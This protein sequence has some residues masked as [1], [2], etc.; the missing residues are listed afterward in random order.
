MAASFQP[1][2]PFTHGQ[3]ARTAVAETLGI[4]HSTARE[5]LARIRSKYVDAGRPAPDKVSLLRRAVE[6]GILPEMDAEPK[7]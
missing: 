3:A 1:E 2:P 7:R 4:A 6:D 5:Y